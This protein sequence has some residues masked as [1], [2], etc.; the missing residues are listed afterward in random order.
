MKSI[1]VFTSD[2]RSF[3]STADVVGKTI[4]VQVSDDFVGGAKTYNAERNEWIDDPQYKPTQE[5]LILKAEFER[6]RLI[7]NAKAVMSDWM[8]DLQL[9]IIEENEKTSLADWREYIKNLKAIDTSV[10][11]DIEWPSEPNNTVITIKNQMS[12]KI[13]SW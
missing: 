7:D 6:L 4:L 2:Y 13:N 10:A 3:A 8:D 5:D 1:Y 12:M 9:G 11:P